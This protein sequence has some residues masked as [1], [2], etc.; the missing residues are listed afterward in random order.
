MTTPGSPVPD[1]VPPD[2]VRPAPPA[3]ADRSA[4]DPPAADASSTSDKPVR[5]KSSD[6]M[7][8]SNAD[9]ETVVNRLNAAFA[10]G[11]LDVGELDDRVAQAYAA[12]TVG[13]LRPLTRDLPKPDGRRPAARPTGGPVDRPTAASKPSEWVQFV[14]F[15]FPAVVTLNLVIWGV[16][17]VSAGHWIYPWWIWI[18]VAWFFG[19]FGGRR[20]GRR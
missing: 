5:E 9:R 10:E 20:H 1:D 3:P 12:K 4:A 19:A 17:A 15:G 11:R 13:E 14:R 2:A 8:A 7:R 18:L 16:V 6:R